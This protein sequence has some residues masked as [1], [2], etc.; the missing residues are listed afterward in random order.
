MCIRDRNFSLSSKAITATKADCLVVGLPE[1]GDWP[2]STK[3]ADEA[4]GGL[5]GQYSKAGDLTGK[6][7]TINTLPLAEQPWPRLMVVGTGKDSD[8]TAQL[9]QGAES[10]GRGSERHSR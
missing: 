8:R 2:E 3:A 1:K 10:H 6:N 9:P 5:I 4:L 7:G